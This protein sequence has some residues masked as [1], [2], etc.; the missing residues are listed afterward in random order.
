MG[1]KYLGKHLILAE[2]E[3]V[4][5]MVTAETPG[6]VSQPCRGRA[7]VEF[8]LQDPRRDTAEPISTFEIKDGK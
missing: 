1:E 5:G 8:Q 7:T 2:G 4:S 6:S 3:D